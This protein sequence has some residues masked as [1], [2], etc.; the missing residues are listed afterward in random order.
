MS[1]GKLDLPPASCLVTSRALFTTCLLLGLLFNSEDGDN[2]FL[3]NV[4]LFQTTWHYDPEECT[5][6]LQMHQQN[7]CVTKGILLMSTEIVCFQYFPEFA[8]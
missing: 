8:V 1:N 3:Q 4:W 2:L 5:H 6:H 7:K